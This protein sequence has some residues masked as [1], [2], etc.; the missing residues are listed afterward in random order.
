M[1]VGD[2]VRRPDRRTQ[3]VLVLAA[4]YVVVRLAVASL[5]GF[6]FHQGWNEGHY[7]LIAR[8]FLDHPVVPGYGDTFVYNVPPGFS[9]AVA[10]SFALFGQSEL[11]A[12]LPSVLATGGLVVATYELGRTVFRDRSVAL[13]G[14]AVLATLPYVQLFGGRAQTDAAMVFLVTASLVAI[15]RGYQDGT[16]GRR[17]LVAGGALFAAAVAAKQ[18]SLLVAGIT[19]LW[20]LGN[21]RLDAETVRKTGVLV[22]ASAAFLLPL[23]G[24]LYL[25]Y[26][27]APAAFVADWEHELFGRTKL[28]AN[29]RL[30]VAIAFGIGVTPPVLAAAAVGVASDLRETAARYRDHV[31]DAPGPSVL[32]WWL[33]CYGAFVF[34]RTPQGHQYYALVLAPPLAL[35]AARGLDVAATALRGLRGHGRETV[36]L[37]LVVLVVAGTVGGTAVLFELSGEVSVAN[38]GGSHVATDAGEYLAASAPDDATVLV[39]NGYGPPVKWYVRDGHPVEAVETYHVSSLD[40]ERL[41]AALEASEGPVYLVYPRPSWG[42]LPTDRLEEVHVSRPY[43]FTLM[44]VVGQSV[45]VDS[46]FTFYLNDRRL[47]VYRVDE[48]LARA[49]ATAAISEHPPAHG[50]R[51]TP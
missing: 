4:G 42:T 15:T 37:A 51:P 50:V 39:E 31:A 30:L 16:G 19:L 38:G 43:R 20:L 49:N 5:S 24:W 13:V 44:G 29:V 45:D 2:R 33:V 8:G 3:A 47:A 21:R 12:R 32:T 34:A 7:A 35:F 1:T 10:A 6:G 14:A 17:L 46:K 11:A 28:F 9:Y 25:N 36:H 23:A 48:S 40:R 22:A 27:I 26:R 18:P 41:V